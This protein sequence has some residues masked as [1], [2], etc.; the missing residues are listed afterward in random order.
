ME[1]TQST[2]QI[3]SDYNKAVKSYKKHFNALTQIMTSYVKTLEDLHVLRATIKRD[4]ALGELVP[5]YVVED[6]T[7]NLLQLEAEADDWWRIILEEC[8]EEEEF[9]CSCPSCPC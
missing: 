7:K 4:Q 9:E 8:T 5:G 6:Q 3:E 1:Q 2:E